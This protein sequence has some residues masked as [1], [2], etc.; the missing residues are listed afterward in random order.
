MHAGRTDTHTTSRPCQVPIP[1]RHPNRHPHRGYPCHSP[2]P[3]SSTS[4]AT[5][6]PGRVELG[7]EP[8]PPCMPC[9]ERSSGLVMQGR[10]SA[11]WRV[12]ALEPG[13]DGRLGW[14]CKVRCPQVRA[15]SRSGQVY[16]PRYDG[17]LSDHVL[18]PSLVRYT[19]A[20]CVHPALNDEQ[21]PL[22][23]NAIAELLPVIT[24]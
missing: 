24:S 22:A 11:L 1:G 20:F 18:P 14:S 16:C 10:M 3:G 4:K 12:E 6:S 17:E 19:T 21:D 13:T 23:A 15:V 9:P 7:L 2:Q 8:L 5:K